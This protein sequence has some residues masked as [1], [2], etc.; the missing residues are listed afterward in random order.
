MRAYARHKL[1]QSGEARALLRR[2]AQH[3][4]ALFCRAE[5]EWENSQPGDWL[6]DYG[7]CIDDVRAALNWVFSDGGDAD[8]GAALTAVTVPFWIHLSLGDGCRRNPDP[9]A[10]APYPDRIEIV[11]SQNLPTS[12]S[13]N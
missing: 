4:L 5:A 13:F 10:V 6:A 9:K 12:H 11:R 3:H 8:L 1:E 2:H 7:R